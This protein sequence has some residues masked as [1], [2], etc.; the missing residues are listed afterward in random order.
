MCVKTSY[1]KRSWV[2]WVLGLL[3]EP[4]QLEVNSF[5]QKE[6]PVLKLLEGSGINQVPVGTFLGRTGSVQE[7]RPLVPAAFLCFCLCW[8]FLCH[9]RELRQTVHKETGRFG[10]SLL[11]ACLSHQSLWTTLWNNGA[12]AMV[13]KP[14]PQPSSSSHHTLDCDNMAD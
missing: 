2:K 3:G 1:L 12:R 6:T 7:A 11:C 10:K 8:T 9:Q 4:G 14:A 5:F 13:P